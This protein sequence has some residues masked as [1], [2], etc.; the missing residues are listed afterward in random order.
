MKLLTEDCGPRRSSHGNICSRTP[1]SHLQDASE[2]TDLREDFRTAF[3][4]KNLVE[5]RVLFWGRK[6][7]NL[8]TVKRPASKFVRL[9]VEK[10]VQLYSVVILSQPCNPD[11]NELA[12]D[13]RDITGHALQFLVVE[14]QNLAKPPSQILHRLAIVSYPSVALRCINGNAPT[15]DTRSC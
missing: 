15:S 9:R 4:W 1:A 13:A 5:V 6:F 14:L 8:A 12:L 10:I 11:T 3:R 2:T 7:W